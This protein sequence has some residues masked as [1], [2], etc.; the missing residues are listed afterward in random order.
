MYAYVW[1]MCVRLSLRLTSILSPRHTHTPTQLYTPIHPHTLPPPSKNPSVNEDVFFCQ[2]LPSLPFELPSRQQVR[3]GLGL[4]LV[5]GLG[6][7]LSVFLVV[8]PPSPTSK[9]TPLSP[10]TLTNPPPHLYIFPY[11]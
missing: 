5:L 7:C 3:L 4:G 9:L 6:P 8:F 11:L 2:Y 10:I 1:C